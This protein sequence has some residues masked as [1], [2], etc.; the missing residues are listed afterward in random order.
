MYP[1]IFK[2]DEITLTKIKTKILKFNFFLGKVHILPSN[3]HP[4]DNVLPKL[5]IVT[6]SPQTTKILSM[7]LLRQTKRLKY[8]YI[9]LNNT[10]IPL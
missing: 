4:I 5:S 9:F 2:N 8:P 7:S 10:K 1:Q 6:M 3:Y